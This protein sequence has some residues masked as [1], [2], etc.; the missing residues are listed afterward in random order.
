MCTIYGVAAT[1]HNCIIQILYDSGIFTALFYFAINV[2][3]GFRALLYYFRR[4]KGD[5]YAI[6]PVLLMPGYLVTSLLA[7]S[8]PP[9]AYSI[10]LV[11]WLVQAPLFEKKIHKLDSLPESV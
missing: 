6:F 7:S 3:S 1:A 9:F 11:Y 8:Y 4:R 2:A 5:A 10:A